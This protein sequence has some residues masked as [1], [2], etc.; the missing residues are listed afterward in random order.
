[1]SGR[2]HWLTLHSH[3]L[4]DAEAKHEAFPDLHGI[5]A[6]GARSRLV[7]DPH[8]DQHRL[9]SRQRLIDQPLEIIFIGRPGAV[10][11]TAAGRDRDQ[12]G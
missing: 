2:S 3:R 5:A 9:G 11:Q 8:S 6:G 1:M 10:R 4:A 7:V 12:I